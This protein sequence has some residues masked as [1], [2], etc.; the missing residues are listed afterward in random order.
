MCVR[1]KR[2]AYLLD[3]DINNIRYIYIYLNEEK[4]IRKKRVLVAES[5]RE[6]EREVR[7]SSVDNTTSLVSGRSTTKPHSLLP[8]LFSPSAF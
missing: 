7:G 3:L 2:K 1:K 8:N 4:R 6:R 5:E